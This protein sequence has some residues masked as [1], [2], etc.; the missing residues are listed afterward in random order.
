MKSRWILSALVLMVAL[1]LIGCDSS[2]EE[3]VAVYLTK[4]NLSV[5]QMQQERLD[6][7]DLADEPVI[8]LSDIVS[9]DAD[10]HIVELTHEAYE[11]LGDARIKAPV[12]GCLSSV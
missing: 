3:G 2:K 8:S 11:R 4:S 7:V 9:C 12:E 5:T 6:G 10:D 1:S